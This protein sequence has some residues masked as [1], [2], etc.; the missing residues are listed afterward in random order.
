MQDLLDSHVHVWDL[1]RLRPTW[2]DA[3]SALDRGFLAADYLAAL[4]GVKSLRAIYLEIDLPALQQSV[5][6]Q[7]VQELLHDPATPFVGAVLRGDPAASDFAAWLA[8]VE[9]EPMV[10]GFRRVL[11]PTDQ[12]RG[13]C[14]D[15]AFIKG[16]R[17]LG[18]HDRHFE[19]CMRS[20]E[21]ADLASLARA[22]PE[23][24][25]VLDHLGN[26]HLDGSDLTAWR[27]GL[28]AVAEQPNVIC[29]VSGL[30][31]NASATWRLEDVSSIIDHARC[32][33][34][35]RRL[36]FGGNWPVCTLRGSLHSWLEA[37]LASTA[38]WSPADL[39]ALLF[40]N[41]AACYRVD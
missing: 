16:I 27:E 15:S 11:H 29:K 30:F 33:F 38:H 22:A 37:V 25:L 10:R 35:V 41:A 8:E 1:A 26:P 6:F 32:C 19:I 40:G 9:R 39:D 3:V 23:T 4:P 17:V 13:R 2:L 24:T 21:L 28:A 34:G 18:Q 14:L 31:Q 36:M 12:P 7:I 20:E 5:E